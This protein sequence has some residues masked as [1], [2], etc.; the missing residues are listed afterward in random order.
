MILNKESETIQPPANWF[1]RLWGFLVNPHPSVQDIGEK[2]RAQLLAI[3]TLILTVAYLWAMI[4][5]PNSY[6]EFVALLLFTAIA[7][8]LSRTPYYEIGTYFFCFG[9]TA[10][11]Y[12]TLY[13]GTANSYT[14]AITTTVHISLIV[15]SILLSF[16]GL[17]VLVFL[18]GIASAT[19]PQYSQVPI[20]I[21]SD[22]FRD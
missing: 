22:F 14:S 9:F 19:A 1:A 11:A 2:R 15:A 4:S 12:I 7:Y 13:L 18:V 5:R 17:A 16:R 10:F 6:S 20:V 3:I 21:N 8:G